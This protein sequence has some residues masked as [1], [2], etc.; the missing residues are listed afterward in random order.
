[1]NYPETPDSSW[2]VAGEIEYYSLETILEATRWAEFHQGS[3][4]ATRCLP[5]GGITNEK[6]ADNPI[7]PGI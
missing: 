4:V 2:E 6:R 1:M 3:E 7:A 5:E